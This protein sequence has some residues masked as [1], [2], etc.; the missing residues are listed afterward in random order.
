MLIYYDHDDGPVV[1]D[2]VR[3]QIDD[4]A[5]AHILYHF[6]SPEV[7]ADICTELD[8]PWRSNGYRYLL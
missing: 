7:L 2:V 6:F 4:G 1:R 3:F 5:V 8:L